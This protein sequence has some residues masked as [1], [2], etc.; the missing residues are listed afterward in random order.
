MSY[1]PAVLQ[2]RRVLLTVVLWMASVSYRLVFKGI[3]VKVPLG[4]ETAP[5]LYARTIG[6]VYRNVELSRR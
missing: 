5:L 2:V 6:G 1:F 4:T 3:A